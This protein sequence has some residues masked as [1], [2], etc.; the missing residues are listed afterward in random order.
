MTGVPHPPD[1]IP[2][3]RAERQER[4]TR[5]RRLDAACLP[6]AL[7][8]ARRGQGGA[9]LQVPGRR[10]SAQITRYQPRGRRARKPGMRE[11]FCCNLKGKCSS[12]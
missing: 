1:Q 3:T 10:R 11:V 8:R 9:H 4:E 6:P 5:R 2:I 12:F 7:P